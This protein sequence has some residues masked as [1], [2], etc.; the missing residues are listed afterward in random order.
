MSLR[1]AVYIQFSV[2]WFT[3]FGMV[4]EALGD[5]AFYG[6]GEPQSF[7]TDNCD[8]ERKALAVTWPSSQQFLCIFHI[9][10][11][12][13][14]WLLNA[15]HG[16]HKN[17]RQELMDAVK[18]LVYAKTGEAFNELLEKTLNN[19]QAEKYPNFKW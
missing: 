3:G 1:N 11:Q 10:Q 19:P 15:K 5:C 8:A 13:W 16:I 18:S 6:K 4:K 17:D 9:L 12:V 7:M 14:R 2:L